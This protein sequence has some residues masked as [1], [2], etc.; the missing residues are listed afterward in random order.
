[1]RTRNTW[2]IQEDIRRRS[3]ADRQRAIK[4]HPLAA[5]KHQIE[6]H[7]TVA[8]RPARAAPG[9]APGDLP[10]TDRA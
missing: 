6:M 10:V 4:R 9:I 3:P 7:R 5:F 8:R 2:V 1:M